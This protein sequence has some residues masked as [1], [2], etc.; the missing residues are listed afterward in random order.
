MKKQRIFISFPMPCHLSQLDQP[1]RNGIE[2]TNSAVRFAKFYDFPNYSLTIGNQ[3]KLS[4]CGRSG[5]AA[6]FQRHI[7]CLIPI[8][9]LEMRLKNMIHVFCMKK[10]RFSKLLLNRLY[11]VKILTWVMILVSIAFQRYIASPVW[12][13]LAEVQPSTGRRSGRTTQAVKLQQTH[14]HQ[15]PRAK[16]ANERDSYLKWAFS[17]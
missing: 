5:F 8:N 12:A 2:N 9:D 7:I 16:S 15:D 17:C 10:K 6:A 3:R 13:M 4:T 11:F 14:V 1:F